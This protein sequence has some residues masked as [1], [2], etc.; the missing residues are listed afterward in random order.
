MSSQTLFS[1]FQKNLYVPFGHDFV[2]RKSTAYRSREEVIKANTKYER[3]FN[4]P[5]GNSSKVTTI[6]EKRFVTIKVAGRICI[7]RIN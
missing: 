3:C 5:R 2:N 6:K 4:S 1:D 7:N